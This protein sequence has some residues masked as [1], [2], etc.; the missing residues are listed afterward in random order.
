MLYDIIIF[1][2]P[3]SGLGNRGP[4]LLITDL[5]YSVYT[6]TILVNPTQPSVI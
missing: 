6:N 5:Q 3:L 1:N 2:F 4:V